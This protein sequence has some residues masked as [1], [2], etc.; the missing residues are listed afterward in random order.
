MGRLGGLFNIA[1]AYDKFRTDDNFLYYNSIKGKTFKVLLTDIETVSIETKSF[2]KSTLKVIGRGTTLGEA[3][4]STM[5]ANKGQ[6]L[7]LKELGKLK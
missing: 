1:L 7:I 5:A 3:T 6:E 4:M 2:G